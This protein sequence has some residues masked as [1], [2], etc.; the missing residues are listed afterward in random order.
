MASSM[1]RVF[2]MGNVT[3]DPELRYIS[4]GSAVTE[5]GLAINDRRKSSSGEWVEETTFVDITLWGRTAEIAGEYVTKGAPLLIEGRLKLDMWEK[6]GK[7]TQ[8]S[9]LLAIGCISLDH[10][11]AIVQREVKQVAVIKEI[12]TATAQTRRISREGMMQEAVLV[13]PVP[14]VEPK[15]TFLSK[16]F[17][18]NPQI[19]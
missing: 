9:V 2:L 16:P 12:K 8:S 4:N 6:D 3:R 10:A 18:D 13:L 17:S 19:T 1:N 15:T 14:Q 5:I 11:E 7:K